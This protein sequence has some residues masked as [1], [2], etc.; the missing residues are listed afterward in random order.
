HVIVAAGTG[1]TMIPAPEM[2]AFAERFGFTF[3]AHKVGDA[4]RSARVEA[5]FHR[6]DKA[7][8]VGSTFTDWRD[9]N[10]RARERCDTWN[11]TFSGLCRYRHSPEHADLRITPTTAANQPRQR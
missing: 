9:L 7:F 6:I 10:A 2:A 3:K 11:A 1:P 4:N 8:L 5:P